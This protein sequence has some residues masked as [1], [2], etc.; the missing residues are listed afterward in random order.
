MTPCNSEYWKTIPKQTIFGFGDGITI[1]DC[2]RCCIA[3]ILHL[4]ASDVPHFMEKQTK[5]GGDAASYANDWLIPNG[6]MLIVLHGSDYF[7]DGSPFHIPLT[8]EYTKLN[9]YLNI[10][11][12]CSGP[13]V[14]SKNSQ[15]THSVVM[16]GSDL[17]YDPHPSN[18]GLLAITIREM[19]IN[20]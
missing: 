17:L 4:P 15:Q 5:N 3:A 1:G 8:S 10:P 14:R 16:S 9:G 18:D 19:V 12:I 2:F 11:I 7:S 6:H 20:V 13:T